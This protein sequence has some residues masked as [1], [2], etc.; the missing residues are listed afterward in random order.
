MVLN[1]TKMNQTVYILLCLASFSEECVQDS[2]MLIYVAI[3]VLFSSLLYSIPL[4]RNTFMSGYLSDFFHKYP[5]T[6]TYFYVLI[7]SPNMTLY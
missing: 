6:D 4:G 2:P 5:V 3:A 1:F 7:Y